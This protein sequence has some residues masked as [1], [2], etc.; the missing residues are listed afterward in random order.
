MAQLFLET[1][2]HYRKEGAFL[3]H[4][5]VVMLDHFHVI[6][7][8]SDKLSL[9][10]TIQRIK[11]GFSFRAGKEINPKMEIWQRSFTHRLLLNAEDYARHRDYICRNPVRRNCHL[12][13]KT[14][15][16]LLL[17]KNSRWILRRIFTAAK[18]DYSMFLN[19]RINPPSSAAG[20]NRIGC[21]K[22]FSR[23]AMRRD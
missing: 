20:T 21:P 17:T 7:T 22:T 5:F 15:H 14:I 8:P 11:G 1:L 4:E 18:A 10:R 16:I 6:L 12:G 3:L 19:G 2:F 9:E 13:R 23:P